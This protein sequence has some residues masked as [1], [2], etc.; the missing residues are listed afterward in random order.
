MHIGEHVGDALVLRD[1]FV[2]LFAFFRVSNRGVECGARD[3]DGLRGNSDAAT[4]EIGQSDTQA[5]ASLAEQIRLGDRAIVKSNRASIGGADTHLV[6]QFVDNATRRFRRHNK[7]AD[8]FL[9]EIG[10]GDR[11]HDSHRG[12]LAVGDELFVAVNN[13]LAVF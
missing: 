11:E 4:F 1:R 6:L 7:S 13:P 2:E 12:A 3:A 10:I 8:A 5:F 9:T